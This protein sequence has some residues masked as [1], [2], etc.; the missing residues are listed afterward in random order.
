VDRESTMH[1]PHTIG[2]IFSLLSSN[3]TFF[4]GDATVKSLVN[5]QRV[6]G[7]QDM[8]MIVVPIQS[9]HYFSK[10]LFG[11]TNGHL[12][13]IYNIIHT[14]IHLNNLKHSVI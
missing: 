1:S 5:N 8:R 7:T 2:Q 10:N 3:Q 14:F 12:F 6:S 9:A 4:A 11:R 13:Y